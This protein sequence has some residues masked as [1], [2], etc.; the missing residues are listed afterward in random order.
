MN[1]WIVFALFLLG[2]GSSLLAGYRLGIIAGYDRAEKMLG[3]IVEEQAAQR[4]W[5]KDGN[6]VAIDR[7][8]YARR[9][10][11]GQPTSEQAK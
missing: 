6:I 4:G 8:I 9:P 3:E 1:V 5:I 10:L 7:A 11:E 2:C